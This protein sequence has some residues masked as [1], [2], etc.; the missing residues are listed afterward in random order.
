M[1]R[2]LLN[3]QRRQLHDILVAAGIDL[4]QTKWTNDQ[5]NW[6]N[7]PADTLEIGLCYF[8]IVPNYSQIDIKCSPA[9]DGGVEFGDVDLSWD[10]V[11]QYFESWATYV[12]LEL[13]QADPW[14]KYIKFS[15]PRDLSE[16][17]DNS[18]FS[19]TEAQEAEEA[20]KKLITFLHEKVDGYSK[21]AERY[22]AALKR[23]IGHA[24]SGLGRVDWSNQFI[25][26]IINICVSLSLS[27]EKANE[28]WRFWLN[29]L[30]KI[31]QLL[32]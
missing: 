18:S 30:S 23:L 11:L 8:V 21:Q 20:I 10:G 14:A 22:D 19:Y 12:K 17:P 32:S 6:T 24:K 4:A 13:G 2:K 27:P 9:P 15:P 16:F 25:G 1:K 3:I 28:I 7:N 31:Y 29:T 5:K 26:L